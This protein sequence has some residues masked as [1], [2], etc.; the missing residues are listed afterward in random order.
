[1]RRVWSTAL[2]LALFAAAMWFAWLGWDHQY[3][4]V[5][6]VYQGPYRPWQVEGCGLSIVVATVI[7]FLVLRRNV[8]I[9]VLA[10]AATIGFS[11]PWSVDAARQD[12]TGLWMVGLFMLLVGGSL[13]LMALLGVTAAIRSAWGAHVG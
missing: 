6:G 2:A 4:K 1:M 12:E 9:F 13:G 11:V 7:A 10:S 5:N 3:Y 8:A